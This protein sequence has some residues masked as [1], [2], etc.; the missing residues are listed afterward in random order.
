MA[1][2]SE[3][4]ARVPPLYRL[5]RSLKERRRARAG[6]RDRHKRTLLRDVAKRYNLRVLV[7]TGTYMGETAWALRRDLERIETIELE[8]TLARL[9]RIRF[10]NVPSVHVHEGDSASVLPRILE[11]LTEP[12]LFW[13]D[14][15]P[16]TDRTAQ[17]TPIPLRAELAAIRSHAV[18]GHVV[19][20]DDV[21]YLGTPGYPTLAEVALPGHRLEEDGGVAVLT[22]DSP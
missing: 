10:R 17:D 3:L 5:A 18:G 15:H 7:E 2:K 19:L 1:T 20:V 9:A 13:L 14:A 6:H 8:P 12:A 22:P 16:S 4:L 11:T 21:Q